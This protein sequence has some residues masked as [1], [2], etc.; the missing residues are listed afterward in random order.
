MP[1]PHE[2]WTIWQL[3]L[4]PAHAV[5][6]DWL[7]DAA[8]RCELSGGQIRNAVLH[9]SQLALDERR[10]IA[11]PDAARAVE[12]EYRKSGAVCPLPPR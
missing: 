4:P 12:R 11:T 5:A 10:P 9:A 1:D 2:R 8:V 6:Y 7:Q 3:H